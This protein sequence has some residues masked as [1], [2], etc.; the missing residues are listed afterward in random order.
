ML[1]T[2]HAAAVFMETDSDHPQASATLDNRY[3][4]E[5]IANSLQPPFSHEIETDFFNKAANQ[6]IVHLQK[7]CGRMKNRLVVFEDGTKACCRYR[8]NQHELRGEL[9]AYQ[10][11]KILDT[12]NVPPS[13]LV[14]LN[15]SSPQ[16]RDVADSARK[17][18][19]RNGNSVILTLYVEDLQPEYL[20][21]ELKSTDRPLT[22]SLLESVS[23][24]KQ[25]R[26]V[27][28]SDLIVFDYI[29]GH[30]DRL[31]SNLFNMQWTPNM[32]DRA[33]HNMAKST[34]GSLVLFDNESTFWLGYSTA[35]K[36]KY[37]AM[38]LYFLQRLCIV[39][40]SVIDKLKEMASD[41]DPTAQVVQALQA[42]NALAFTEL[43]TIPEKF[44]REFHSRLDDVLSRIQQCN[45]EETSS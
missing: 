45:G 30:S 24:D 37:K 12:W 6:R 13:F 32:L 3:W 31:F 9:Y 43:G 17:A 16:W 11:S 34:T 23:N 21:E 19:W 4:S 35:E 14:R 25:I 20:P 27:Q 44:V 10:L 26:L 40:K 42:S 7:G 18:E 41:P 8:E 38:Q 36:A 1:A 33:V 28:W 5:S 15:L 22:S 39:R 29:V 2:L